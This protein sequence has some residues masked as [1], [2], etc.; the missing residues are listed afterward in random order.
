MKK[1]LLSLSGS[2]ILAF[3]LFHIHSLGAVTEGGTL[4]LTLLLHHWFSVS[5]AVSGFILNGACYLIGIQVLGRS[6]LLWS[7]LSGGCFSVFYWVFEQFPLLWP[8]LVHH[9]LASAILG[10]LFVGVGVGLCVKAGGAPSGDDALAMTFSHLLKCPIERIYLV[11][12]L[13]V[14]ALSMSYIPP[15]KIVYSLITVIL[16]GQIIGLLQK[17]PLLT[18]AP[19]VMD[20]KK[21]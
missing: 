13:A 12:D 15:E 20:S 16:S 10:G 6:F 21:A 7:F 14:L 2:A 8:E 19:S 17:C 4:G 18:N 9:P 3:G 1:L 5:P 11:T